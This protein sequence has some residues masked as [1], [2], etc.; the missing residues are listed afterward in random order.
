MPP[1]LLLDALDA[2]DALD[3]LLDEELDS[4]LDDEADEE[5]EEFDAL[6]DADDEFP[7]PEPPTLVRPSTSKPVMQACVDTTKTAAARNK[8]ARPTMRENRRIARACAL[9]REASSR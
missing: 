9:A 6:L 2:L 7:L 8:G 4:P 3:V 5:D 1:L